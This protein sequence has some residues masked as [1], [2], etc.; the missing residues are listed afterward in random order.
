MLIVCPACHEGVDLKKLQCQKCKGI[1]D[2]DE[3]MV[4]DSPVAICPACGARQKFSRLQ[5]PSCRAPID[6]ASAL[7]QG[8]SSSATPEQPVRAAPRPQ[9]QQSESDKVVSKGATSYGLGAKVAVGA[10]G[11]ALLTLLGFAFWAFVLRTSESDHRSDAIRL[12]GDPAV[13]SPHG[14][15]VA[16]VLPTLGEA[17]ASGSAPT[18]IPMAAPTS[19][20]TTTAGEAVGEDEGDA[21]APESPPPVTP[22][23]AGTTDGVIVFPK[24]GKWNGKGVFAGS[25]IDITDLSFTV[26]KGG[27]AVRD[28]IVTY[29]GEHVRSGF[30][31]STGFLRID[32]RKVNNKVEDSELSIRFISPTEAKGEVKI[33]HQGIIGVE[34]PYTYY[35]RFTATLDTGQAAK[36]DA[37]IASASSQAAIIGKVTVTADQAPI[38]LGKNI[39]Q[40]AKKGNVLDVTQVKGDWYCVLP[41]H[42]WVEKTNVTYE[43][44]A[45]PAAGVLPGK[46]ES[47]AVAEPASKPPAD[48]VL[49]DSAGHVDCRVLSK[50]TSVLAPSDTGGIR[51]LG[52][53]ATKCSIHPC[54]YILVRLSHAEDH[55]TIGQFAVVDGDGKPNGKL[56]CWVDAADVTILPPPRGIVFEDSPII[57]NLRDRQAVARFDDL[58][59]GKL[60]SDKRDGVLVFDGLGDSLQGL[61]LSAPGVKIPLVAGSVSRPTTAEAA[62][63]EGRTD[64]R[65]VQAWQRDWGAFC[66]EF[67]KALAETKVSATSPNYWSN[68][69]R[70][71]YGATVEWSG[72]VLDIHAFPKDKGGFLM[73]AMTPTYVTRP[74][75][76]DAVAH[77]ILLQVGSGEWPRWTGVKVG[78]TI[79]Y[80]ASLKDDVSIR[81]DTKGMLAKMGT[82]KDAK[83]Y[84]VVLVGDVALG[85]F[86]KEL[87]A[88]VIDERTA[89]VDRFFDNA[90]MLGIKESR[91]VSSP[92]KIVSDSRYLVNRKGNWKAFEKDPKNATAFLLADL[93]DAASPPEAI[94]FLRQIITAGQDEVVA[95]LGAPEETEKGSFSVPGVT[96]PKSVEVTFLTYG[97]FTAVCERAGTKD[98]IGIRVNCKRFL[99]LHEAVKSLE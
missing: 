17:A 41:T 20:P 11:A 90:L 77:G 81:P 19:T 45:A 85:P 67:G 36:K 4:P 58:L 1:I 65:G 40:T 92:E 32:D 38:M 79:T 33:D 99:D 27:N 71:F 91:I 89:R 42:C 63:S 76:G 44:V 83:Y 78:D 68:V 57:K 53:V 28:F 61:F 98:L 93:R 8:T 9:P 88:R 26:D 43:P 12:R 34:E 52:P 10:T 94:E 80:R 50:Y 31:K 95:K 59:S 96:V 25:N 35:G 48:S 30:F 97:Y 62:R 24:D 2:V 66:K 70:P 82:V 84:V 69:S 74:E 55:K 13:G 87:E 5:C 15:K 64:V 16:Q 72:T 51:T 22:I 75:G 21:A 73:V 46:K 37:S 54:L 86:D 6:V 29:K 60:T 47:S 18:P 49:G 7:P 3:N 14:E 23:P 39:V 56:R